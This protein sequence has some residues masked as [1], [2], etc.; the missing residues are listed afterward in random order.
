VSL[1]PL[2]LL[3]LLIVFLPAAA[4]ILAICAADRHQ[5]LRLLHPKRWRAFTLLA[6]GSCAIYCPV[7]A[8]LVVY[9]Y[10][11][12]KAREPQP[13][14][15]SAPVLPRPVAPSPTPRPTPVPP[16]PTP[17]PL[18][19]IVAVA[20]TD[21]EGVYVRRTPGWSDRIKAYPD[22]TNLELLGPE[23]EAENAIWLRVRAPDGLAGWVPKQYTS[24][25][26][27]AAAPF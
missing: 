12:Q 8:Y 6:Y 2:A 27:V 21:G 22:G 17:V 4:L 16:R 3:V 25:V 20:N 15:A 13:V 1:S 23:T 24:V 26:G 10:H 9:V 19:R 5:S 7:F 14:V 11:E 18:P